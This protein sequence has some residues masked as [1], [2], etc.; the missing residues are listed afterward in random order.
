MAQAKEIGTPARPRNSVK[1]NVARKS[2]KSVQVIDTDIVLVLEDGRKLFIR[3]GAVQ[4]MVDASFAVEFLDGET[5]TGQELLQSSG[6]AEITPLTVSGPQSASD[7]VNGITEALP[8]EPV[9]SSVAD[10]KSGQFG[11]MK[12]WLAIGTP[13]IGGA[14]GGVLSAGGGAAAASTPPTDTNTK[15]ATPVIAVVA[16]ND[17]VNAAEKAAGVVVSGTAEANASIT[18]IWGATS[19]TATANASG[20]WTVNFAANEVPAD[21]AGTT[22][23]ATVKST[24][25]LSSDPATRTIEVDTQAPA[26]PVIGIVSTD[27]IISPSEKAAGVTV[28]GLAESN[29]V[30]RVALG[31]VNKSVLA[32]FAGNWTASFNSAE[33]PGPGSYQITASAS[34]LAG[35]IGA[36]GA[37][38]IIVAAAIT[39]TGQ[40][41]A[42][43]LVAGH[44]LTVDI[45]NGAGVLLQRG[46][47]VAA[48]G[49]FTVVGLQVGNG[50]III[51]RVSDSSGG[52]DYLDEATG[53]S[54]DL[55]A[56]FLSV[57]VV[58][59]N[60]MTININPLTTLAA[61]KAGL[62]VDGTGTVADATLVNRANAQIAEAF[63]LPSV[64]LLGTT[65]APVNGGSFEPT[66]GLTAGEKIGVVLAA[67]SGLDALANGNSQQTINI[68]SQSL[69]TT[70]AG[71]S[72]TDVAKLSLMQGA[73]AAETGTGAIP[74]AMSNLLAAAP[75]GSGNN[76]AIDVVAGDNIVSATELQGLVVTGTVTT[77]ATA[78]TLSLGG[79]SVDVSL[80][81]PTWSYTLT[82][83][84]R[85]ALAGD[86]PKLIKATATFG[87]AS[88]ESSRAFV[89]KATIPS[90][91]RFDAIAGD[92][93]IN[94][95][96]VNQIIP[97][98]GSG[99]PGSYVSVTGPWAQPKET[100][101]D[102]NG[103]WSVNLLPTDIPA[104]GQ[105]DFTATARDA[106]NNT[107]LV[108]RASVVIDTIA[109]ALPTMLALPNGG[110]I[111]PLYVTGGLKLQGTGEFLGSIYVTLGEYTA[112]PVQIT[113][114]ADKSWQVI[115][116]TSKLPSDGI[117]NI[118]I[119]QTDQAKNVSAELSVP[120]TIDFVA[121]GAPTLDATAGALS[122]GIINL[123]EKNSGVTLRGRYDISATRITAEW[124]AQG[125]TSGVLGRVSLDNGTWSAVFSSAQIPA[126]GATQLLLTASDAS[127]NKSEVGR[128]NITVDT[129]IGA[130]SIDPVSNNADN[131]VNAVE[132]QTFQIT[133]R[134]DPSVSISLKIQSLDG[135]TDYAS[136]TV[137]T[138]S[139]ETSW[140]WAVPSQ[141]TSAPPPNGTYKITAIATDSGLNKTLLA[142]RQFTLDTTPPASVTLTSIADDGVVS[143]PELDSSANLLV[144]GSVNGKDVTGVKLRFQNAVTAAEF[145]SEYV[146]PDATGQWALIL[147]KTMLEGLLE[148]SA[149]SVEVIAKDGAG[150]ESAPATRTFII[151][152]ST[153]SASFNPIQIAGLT[154]SNLVGAPALANGI[155]ISGKAEA[156]ATI[157]LSW[158]WPGKTGEPFTAT[159]SKADSEGNWSYVIPGDRLQTDGTVTVTAVPTDQYGNSGTKTSYSFEVDRTVN[160]FTFDNSGLLSVSAAA[161]A[162]TKDGTINIAER[163]AGLDLAGTVEPGS[164]L[165]F[166]WVSKADP[167]VR[168]KATNATVSFNDT[169][170]ST[171]L[172]TQDIPSTSGDWTL[173]IKAI[174]RAGNDQ[175]I[176]VES[177]KVDLES[178]GNVAMNTIASSPINEAQRSNV[179]VSGSSAEPGAKVTIVWY[180]L[181]ENSTLSTPLISKTI[182][183]NENG[184]WSNSFNISGTGAGLGTGTYRVK[185]YQTDKAG[186]VS[187][188]SVEQDVVVS[189]AKPAAPTVDGVKLANDATEAPLGQN[190]I[191]GAKNHGIKIYGTGEP[192]NAGLTGNKIELT[193][194]G[195]VI[196]D[197]SVIVDANGN[198][199]ATIP[200]DKV[201]NWPENESITVTAKQI[202]QSNNTSSDAS[203]AKSFFVDTIA[204]AAPSFSL[205]V[206][207]VF[208]GLPLVDGR[209][210]INA[211]K[212]STGFTISGT[213]EPKST[214]YTRWGVVGADGSVTW[215]V[216]QSAVATN[217]TWSFT[218]NNANSL[219]Q[220]QVVRLSVYSLD[221][222][223]NKSTELTRDVSV[224][225]SPPTDL[226][227]SNPSFGSSINKAE[228]GSDTPASITV[229]YK[230]AS[231][232]RLFKT[233]S[234]LSGGTTD[235]PLA[236]PITGL[237]AESSTISFRLKDLLPQNP[238]AGTVTLKL[239]A[240]D[241][242]GN[243]SSITQNYDYNVVNPTYNIDSNPVTW[244]ELTDGVINSS[245]S[246]NPIALS[247]KTPGTIA[248]VQALFEISGSP[249][250]VSKSYQGTSTTD[251]DGFKIWTINVPAAEVVNFNKV[252]LSQ[253]DNFGNT[254]A[255]TSKI[256][257]YDGTPIANL[258]LSTWSGTD[259]SLNSADIGTNGP[260]L[261]FTAGEKPSRIAVEFFAPD[262]NQP[263]Q[264]SGSALKTFN[265]SAASI[266]EGN[267]VYRVTLQ[268]AGLPDDS[269]YILRLTAYDAAGNATAVTQ[270]VTLDRASPNVPIVALEDTGTANNDGITNTGK[271]TITNIEANAV[272][273]VQIGSDTT[274][275]AV[276]KSNDGYHYTLSENSSAIF[277]MNSIRIRQKD[278]AG[279]ISQNWT[280]S[281]MILVDRVAPGDATIER[282]T[283]TTVGDTDYTKN[284][285]FKVTPAENKVN[286]EYSSDGGSTW[287]AAT[288]DGSNFTFTL[289]AA[290]YEANRI[291]VR[292]TDVAGNQKV[293]SYGY[294]VVVDT[295]APAAATITVPTAI[296]IRTALAGISLGISGEAN[297]TVTVTAA[298]VTLGGPSWSPLA[299]ATTITLPTTGQPVQVPLPLANMPNVTSSS[300]TL[301]VTQTDRAG[302]TTKTEQTVTLNLGPQTIAVSGATATGNAFTTTENVVQL[303]GLA[304]P[305]A[306]V[307]I[308]RAN[309][310]DYSATAGADGRWTLQ[311]VDLSTVASGTPTTFT[312]SSTDQNSITA[313][314]TTFTITRAAPSTVTT[315]LMGG[316][317]AN[318]INLA[319]TANSPGLLISPYTTSGA[320]GQMGGSYAAGHL[321][322]DSNVDYIIGSPGTYSA[323]LPITSSTASQVDILLNK[324][325]PLPFTLTNVD[326][327]AAGA[328]TGTYFDR[329]TIRSN[330]VNS[331]F[332]QSVAIMGSTGTAGYVFA[333]GAP[334][335]I[336]STTPTAAVG[337]GRVYV[338]YGLPT[339]TD[340]TNNVFD[341]AS[342]VSR[343]SSTLNLGTP[344]QGTHGFIFEG[345]PGDRLGQSISN[346]GDISGD[347]YA[348]L[349]IGIRG[350]DNNTLNQSTTNEGGVLILYGGQNGFLGANGRTADGIYRMANVGAAGSTDKP[351]QGLLITGSVANRNMGVNVTNIRDFN[352][353]GIA[354]FLI[355]NR[356]PN[357]GTGVTTSDIAYV[358]Y[359]K[360]NRTE[361]SLNV[362]NLAAADGLVLRIANSDFPA[363]GPSTGSAGDLNGDG[364]NDIVI[365]TPDSSRVFVVFG[366]NPANIGTLGTRRELDLMNMPSAQGFTI[367][368][369]NGFMG[370]TVGT[371]GDLNG[372]GLS[373]LYISNGNASS[374]SG[375]AYAGGAVILYG[376]KGTGEAWAS[377][378][379]NGKST[380]QISGTTTSTYAISPQDGLY[381]AG[382]GVNDGTGQFSLSLSMLPAGDFGGDGIADFF[383]P[384]LTRSGLGGGYILP[385]AA[386]Y[387]GK[388]LA[389]TANADVLMGTRYNDVLTAS[390]AD[391]VYGFDGL[392]IINLQDLNFA[393][394]DGGAGIDMLR[395][396]GSGLNLDLTSGPVAQKLSSI[397]RIDMTGSGANTLSLNAAALL[398]LSDD[399]VISGGNSLDRLFVTADAADTVN[400]FG[401]VQNGANQTINGITYVSYTASANGGTAQL[402]VSQGTTVNTAVIPG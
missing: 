168:Q 71:T 359:G 8:T 361:T 194:N 230:G 164:T 233:I 222:V 250:S 40:I 189:L 155:T 45:Y 329:L 41:T 74:A 37:R 127:G 112:A 143:G 80:N 300:Y 397:E 179:Q 42:G 207:N 23:S 136:A 289:P 298:P 137:T 216:P 54:K 208:D 124:V 292:Q 258:A 297:A 98:S 277:G 313:A 91:P 125:N 51:A 75:T 236:D 392:D 268:S 395:L 177:V 273:E 115:I 117:Y 105:I 144:K 200:A 21:A 256:F 384:A 100:Q 86:G 44:G 344:D 73:A 199:S 97:I 212:L 394:I 183:A 198:W 158:T 366:G 203:T 147:P 386:G 210:M 387:G 356:S 109:P 380:F 229:G 93:F 46:V 290:T 173:E 161:P 351:L 141:F 92:G 209:P 148:G 219:P 59:S 30:V 374:V 215:Q 151:D 145:V 307:T 156:F 330:S 204:P 336:S 270:T 89:L 343:S 47:S 126:D 291:Q 322:G 264:A 130:V 284:T 372:D 62:A 339:A 280:N 310:S 346:V 358:I 7:E 39:V 185:A 288:A 335:A 190:I 195:R 81:G 369:L 371:V 274:W 18:V 87:N 159:T 17:R 311:G 302:N 333:V 2:V 383:M 99:T 84:D 237:S 202:Y 376:R 350:Y 5:L 14:I 38:D 393:G 252:T 146:A 295:T 10:A 96:E 50:D 318:L 201:A 263:S 354:D 287:T 213:A 362:D 347:G 114:A 72:L 134:A 52:S 262:P 251:A 43:P 70:S 178:P 327:N 88:V 119:Y 238:E 370:R 320:S 337:P 390:G 309:F 368:G 308:K 166:T 58:T 373:D 196:D 4:T 25:G 85:E 63:G 55:N 36:S 342:F 221:G 110:V 32:D 325:L 381:I 163:T 186:N 401:F 180:G 283:V 254:G 169:A 321:N 247:F 82:A 235:V 259:G 367:T 154:T 396:T 3:D 398:A 399:T 106:Y 157:A 26:A 118:K 304:K 104:S 94:A 257:S 267:S 69:V 152:K 206:L 265:F 172:L 312:L 162:Y 220:G 101:V 223:G 239:V 278:A 363:F 260:I 128:Y 332:G 355:M 49:T 353:D 232:I 218:F 360:A 389:G 225:L 22:I 15:P 66:D 79:R 279:N 182:T 296:D 285:T 349:A 317:Q 249:Q 246:S 241:A 107:S 181:Q 377:S 227:F 301:S 165:E 12:S 375:V 131:I 191:A 286:L 242:A 90:A 319:S 129:S 240:L 243:Q 324:G 78:M 34:D 255:V 382:A 228:W 122:D 205:D 214:T 174:D 188:S 192:H 226:T 271:L 187:A 261:N 150:N 326:L 142:E 269:S 64:D 31:G 379:T 167:T 139:S 244:D 272:V 135:K 27:N 340:V 316:N 299:T 123:N 103:R 20:I 217:G 121:P 357:N 197:G 248:S 67:L 133:G 211:S 171:K 323:S 402:W 193:I 60:S 65:V 160:D 170:W 175:T 293:T 338:F 364:F 111:S 24:A 331:G 176:K 391:Y 35:N 76:V 224:D 48:N 116:P 305:G 83:A 33:I 113:N 328:N 1:V 57:A 378:V 306:T 303:A 365:G 6:V 334:T 266:V 11:G 184:I 231:S 9:S 102:A 95:A 253:T 352:G 61:L 108:T 140:R 120:I 315:T 53:A 138:S 68:L 153:T 28:S 314:G 56:Q 19:K 16:S 13:L 388:T 282:N 348:D 341:I 149:Y 400:A 77:G 245:E 234:D 385:G 276:A 345:A 294:K 29:S 132:L 275:T 281:S